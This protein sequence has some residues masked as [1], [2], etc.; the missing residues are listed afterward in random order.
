MSKYIVA[1]GYKFQMADKPV[2]AGDEVELT[3]QEAKDLGPAV[4]PASQESSA[5][6][7]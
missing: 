5:P 2:Q 6:E 3:E 1:P 4:V 7:A